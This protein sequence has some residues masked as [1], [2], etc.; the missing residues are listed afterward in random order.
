MLNAHFNYSNMNKSVNWGG[1]RMYAL[2]STAMQAIVGQSESAV[3]I[4][5]GI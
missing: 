4:V 1:S 2:T 5:D 3:C